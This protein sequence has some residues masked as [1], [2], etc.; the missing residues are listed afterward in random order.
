MLC[1]SNAGAIS[2]QQAAG[3][4]LPFASGPLRKA[5]ASHLR[6]LLSWASLVLKVPLGQKVQLVAPAPSMLMVYLPPPQAVQLELMRWAEKVPARQALQVYE[7]CPLA[8]VPA[9]LHQRDM[10]HIYQL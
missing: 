8:N 6:H 7:P 3:S 9:G 1:M 5:G 2:R 10:A 4:R